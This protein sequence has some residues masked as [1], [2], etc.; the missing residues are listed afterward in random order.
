[1]CII[2]LD[3]VIIFSKTPK[4][5]LVR[6]QAVFEK[7]VAAGL[8]L[9]PSKCE[10]FKTRI[11]Y[12]G[13]V[14]SENGKECDAKKIEVILKGP[15]PTTATEVR[16]FL[17]F[18]NYYRRF[19]FQFAHIA[20]ALNKLVSGDNANHKN[21]LVTWMD[22]CQEAFEK[23]KVACTCAPVLAYAEYSKRFTLQTDASGLELGAVLYQK[24]DE[25]TPR[26]IAFAS[27]SLSRCESNYPAYKLEL[28]ALKWAVCDRFHEY[29][30]GSEFDV[31]TDNNPLTYINR[32][33]KLD[34]VGQRW[35]A[36]LASYMFNMHYQ[37]GKTNTATD[38]LS[39]IKWAEENCNQCIPARCLTAISVAVIMYNP[40][41]DYNT[42]PTVTFKGTQKVT[43]NMFNDDWKRER[44]GSPNIGE[45]IQNL[46]K[47][48][49]LKGK[50]S[51]GV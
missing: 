5:H 43:Q 42:N 10:F 12:L 6:L 50:L 34:A 3:D 24:D 17:G 33:A 48:T 22:E 15:I 41:L 25:E 31:Y 1:M 7:L 45:I 44:S 28:L 18:C 19:I 27:H 38:A 20:W 11:H 9:K 37:T 32:T 23:L 26:P 49:M 14:V 21:H 2:Y 40:L 16:Q 13:H 39:H 30:Y 51:L 35:V 46:H 36:A 29:V 8:K 47:E 4:E